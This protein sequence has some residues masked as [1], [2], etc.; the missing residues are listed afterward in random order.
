VA[1]KSANTSLLSHPELPTPPPALSV[2]VNCPFD[3]DYRPIREAII[4]T[5]ACCG[6][7]PRSA[8]ESELSHISRM[9]R[10]AHGIFTSNYSVHDLS[11][12]RGEG[13][14]LFARFNMP[15]ELGIAMGRWFLSS[16]LKRQRYENIVKKSRL[17]TN[18]ME[19][20]QSHRWLVLVPVDAEKDR[21][22]SDLKAFDF[23]NHGGDI[24]KTVS[25]VVKWL[26]VADGAVPGITPKLILEALPTFQERKAIRAAKW[27]GPLPWRELV[28]AALE[29]V[30]KLA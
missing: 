24:A 23:D 17:V 30:P 3:D 1:D 10:I 19:L 16:G 18:L 14:E 25:I 28:D 9:E 27:T 15:L 20:A 11:R 6:F 7:R 13:T 4:F 8:D 22:V 21:Y 5:I 29:S 2:F 12:C 26:G